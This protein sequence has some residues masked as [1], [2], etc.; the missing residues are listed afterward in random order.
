MSRRPI[1]LAPTVAQA[2]RA[3]LL[4]ARAVAGPVLLATPGLVAETW[5]GHVGTRANHLVRLVGARD[6]ALCA[7]ALNALPGEP[8]LWR[9]VG[10]YADLADG[11]IAVRTAWRTRR[12]TAV[13]IAAAAFGAAT[14]SAFL[15]RR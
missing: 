11:I 15:D 12:M 1:G 7:G 10:G 13:A 3:G 8:R 14:T 2:V 9:R 6:V 4:A 5:L